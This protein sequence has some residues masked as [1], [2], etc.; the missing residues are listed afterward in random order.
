M[1]ISK[2]RGLEHD[3]GSRWESKMPKKQWE[4]DSAEVSVLF[5]NLPSF[6]GHHKKCKWDDVADKLTFAFL[7]ITYEKLV[8]APNTSDAFMLMNC[9]LYP[10]L[11]YFLDIFEVS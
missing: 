11:I 7:Q 2:W 4:H 10:E 6:L 1:G 9:I 3:C 8:I 5:R